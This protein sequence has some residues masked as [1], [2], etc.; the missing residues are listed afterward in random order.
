MYVWIDT[1]G[2]DFLGRLEASVN[3]NH[4]IHKQFVFLLIFLAVHKKTDRRIPLP[5]LI[6]LFWILQ[7]TEVE[8]FGL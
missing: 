6:K 7:K 4:N 3:L 8:P 2:Q 5:L 1:T